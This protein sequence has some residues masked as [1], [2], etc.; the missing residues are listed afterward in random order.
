MRLALFCLTLFAGL[1]SCKKETIDINSFWQCN[2][3]QNLDTTAISSKL[4][5]SWT[6]SKQS[7]FWTGKTKPADRNIKVTF[8]TNRTFSVNENSNVLTKG[9]W[10]LIQVDGTSSGIDLSA[11]SEFLYGRILFCANQVLFADSYQD[12]CDNLFNKSN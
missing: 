1:L 12:G 7:C 8:K 11:P 6:W 10:K 4:I 2:Q 5:G 3:S 9:T